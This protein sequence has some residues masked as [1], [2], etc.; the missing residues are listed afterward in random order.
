LPYTGSGD[1]QI[2]LAIALI[3]IGLAFLLYRDRQVAQRTR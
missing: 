2:P 3:G 1:G